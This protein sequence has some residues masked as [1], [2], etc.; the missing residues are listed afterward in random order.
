MKRGS[1]FLGATMALALIFSYI[2]FSVPSVTAQAQG[3]QGRQFRPGHQPDGTFVGADGT[4]Y[5]SQ[6]AFVESGLRCGT[7]EDSADERGSGGG[8]GSAR[9][10]G[11]GGQPWPGT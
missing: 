6:Q 4:H 1:L 7:R 11:G 8:S 5:V 10:G 2:Q 9:P 3:G